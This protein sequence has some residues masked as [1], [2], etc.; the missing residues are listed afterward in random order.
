MLE[1]CLSMSRA[2]LC[3]FIIQRDK[4]S[5]AATMPHLSGG[6]GD[7]T[8]AYCPCLLMHRP[9]PDDSFHFAA[10]TKQSK[11]RQINTFKRQTNSQSAPFSIQYYPR[12]LFTNF[13]RPFLSPL[14]GIFTL[15]VRLCHP[16]CFLGFRFTCSLGAHQETFHTWLVVLL[17][18]ASIRENACRRGPGLLWQHQSSREER[19]LQSNNYLLNDLHGLLRLSVF[20]LV[21]TVL[22]HHT[23]QQP[24]CYT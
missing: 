22:F 16:V 18:F 21:L 3:S 2:S 6:H 20:R 12:D 17:L 15:A 11:V 14:Y 10:R 4:S 13:L 23:K 9:P 8:R 7:L 24:N 1:L 19:T 5:T